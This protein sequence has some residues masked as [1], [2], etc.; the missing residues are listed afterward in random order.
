MAK[1]LDLGHCPF[2]GG[3]LAG[4]DQFPIPFPAAGRLHVSEDGRAGIIYDDFRDC[5]YCNPRVGRPHPA[6]IAAAVK[7]MGLTLDQWL[8]RVDA[9]AHL[10][11]GKCHQCDCHTGDVPTCINCTVGHPVGHPCCDKFGFRGYTEAEIEARC[12]AYGMIAGASASG[13]RR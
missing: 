2:C 3:N 4:E 9:F 12:D 5:D 8:A 7:A 11:R 1:Y 13:R 6:V 10:K